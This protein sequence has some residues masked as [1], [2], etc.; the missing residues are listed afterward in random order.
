LNPFRI[1]PTKTDRLSERD[2]SVAMAFK[3]AWGL[4]MAI[5]FLIVGGGIGGAVLAHLL[6]RG[7]KRVVLL[8]KNLSAAPPTRPEVLW[9]TTVEL[10]RTLIPA[11]LEERWLLLVRGFMAVYKRQPIVSFGPEVFQAAGVQPCSTAHTRDLLLQQAPCECQR[12]VEV[13][14]LLREGG[15]VV[16]VRTKDATGGE[17][18]ILA[19][20]VVGDDGGHSIIRRACGLPM[21]L[22]SFPLEIL[23]F[24]F[25]WPASLPAGVA[26]VWINQH[27][28]R[29]G[30]PVMP[31][32]PLPGGK[33]VALIP[34]PP[35]V[36]ADTARL[37][38]A[39]REFFAQDPAMGDVIGERT[40]PD[41]LTRLHIVWGRKPHFGVPGALLMGD[42][43]HPVS[44][45]GGQGA[46]LAVAD[47]VA[48]AET[49][50]HAPADLL[51]AY[52][53][54]RRP[55]AQRSLQL[56]RRAAWIF[57]LPGIVRTLGLL[58]VP[59]AARWLNRR[60]KLFGEFLRISASAFLDSRSV[61]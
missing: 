9:P 51:N 35:R 38:E 46:N 22:S 60:P 17:C 52:E 3:V 53:R 21:V 39:L 23:S 47:A 31:V 61:S 26:R 14:G 5:D 54:R 24:A 16:G 28:M 44:P 34:V 43:A 20:W 19:E 36:L 58:A 1:D 13:I 2:F 12:G 10:L 11:D 45:A 37:H 40:Y 56:T 42:A 7:G 6:G 59:W 32:F 48:I 8:E 27:R 41:S 50:L 15:R 18:D 57:S 25:D 30:I 33:G 29:S 55:A 49:A 4:V